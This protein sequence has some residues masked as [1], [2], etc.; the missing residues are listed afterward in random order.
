MR[1]IDEDPRRLDRLR[2]GQEVVV[3]GT[4]CAACRKVVRIDKF[5]IGSLHPCDEEEG[6]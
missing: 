1:Q 6:H 4:C 3:D 2:P 5:L